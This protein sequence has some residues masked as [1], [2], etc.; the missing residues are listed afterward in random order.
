MHGSHFHSYL[1]S[2]SYLFQR[3]RFQLL[4][5]CLSF[6]PCKQST[7]TAAAGNTIVMRMPSAPTL[8]RGTAAPANQATWATGPSAEVGW[9]L[10]GWGCPWAASLP[11]LLVLLSQVLSVLL[12]IDP[13]RGSCLWWGQR[14]RVLC[15]REEYKCSESDFG[16]EGRRCACGSSMVPHPGGCLQL[17]LMACVCDGCAGGWGGRL[18]SE[19]PTQTPRGPHSWPLSRYLLG[20]D[21]KS[22]SP[23]LC[24]EQFRGQCSGFCLHSG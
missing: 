17:C 21:A 3:Q 2:S 14:A 10:R 22:F 13:D 18:F 16:L 4:K 1:V 11:E 8:S 20:Y 12:V 7:T 23:S 15:I 19:S 6:L 9:L 5:R 24:L